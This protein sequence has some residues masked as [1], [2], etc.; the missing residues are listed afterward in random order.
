MTQGKQLGIALVV[1]GLLVVVVSL[2]ADAIGLGA[3]PATIGWK[4][5]LGALAGLIVAAVG[6]WR[7]RSRPPDSSLE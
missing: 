6:I 7:W 4:Q 3:E 1:L 5:Q 2:A